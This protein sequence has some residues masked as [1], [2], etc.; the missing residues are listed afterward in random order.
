M[1]YGPVLL[2]TLSLIDG[3]VRSNNGLWASLLSPSKNYKISLVDKKN[4]PTNKLSQAELE[5]ADA[6]Y[7][8]FGHMDRF[9]LADKTH[10]FTEWKN[11]NGS[12]IPISYMDILIAVGFE[13]GDAN[14][15]LQELQDV[16]CAK[17]FLNSL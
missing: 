4:I 12:A 8:Q 5:I 2:N 11:P 10:E 7:A 6:V 17:E 15:I 13:Q 3:S 14:N 16:K 1:N 9:D